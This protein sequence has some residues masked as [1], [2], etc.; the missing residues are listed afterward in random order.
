MFLVYIEDSRCKREKMVI[1]KTFKIRKVKDMVKILGSING[2][3]DLIYNGLILNDDETI[4]DYEI[5]P[6]S[7]IQ[8]IG[9]FLAGNKSIT[10]IS[11]EAKLIA[12]NKNPKN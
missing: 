4:E 6:N 9:Q 11:N 5:K 8:Y 2:E 3:I 7:V 1:E 10:N 12:G